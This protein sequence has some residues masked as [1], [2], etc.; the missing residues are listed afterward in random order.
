V[1]AYS[2]A[3]PSKAPRV[4]QLSGFWPDNVRLD[5]QGRLLTAG[6]TNP[7]IDARKQVLP[8]SAPCY[9]GYVV[10]A[11]D[12]RTMASR[13]LAKG[14]LNASF[15]GPTIAVPVG[16]DLWIGSHES[17]RIAYIPAR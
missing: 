3:E 4:A 6:G 7:C 10:V 8:E 15:T 16:K 5:D 11:I 9:R 12:P 14:P 1:L 2:R 13:V 17:D